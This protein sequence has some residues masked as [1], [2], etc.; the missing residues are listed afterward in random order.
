MGSRNFAI[1]AKSVSEQVFAAAVAAAPTELRFC[2]QSRTARNAFRGGK[3]SFGLSSSALC[4]Y[5]KIYFGDFR[6][7]AL[8]L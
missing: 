7:F 2:L 8:Q 3:T 6:S 4:D 5:V 1:V